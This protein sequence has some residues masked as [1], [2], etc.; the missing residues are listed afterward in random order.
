VELSA[1]QASLNELTGLVLKMKTEGYRFV[2]IT[3]NE[4]DENNMDLIYH[5][6]KDLD[7]IHFRCQVEKNSHVPSISPLYFASFLVE[8]EIND[9]F[10]LIFDNLVLDFGGSLL[11]ENEV[12]T[13]PF[14]KYGIKENQ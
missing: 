10:G 1:S 9:Q 12:R 14:C 4:L 13:T 11:L 8:N 5:F 2:T 3:C 6:D 7:L